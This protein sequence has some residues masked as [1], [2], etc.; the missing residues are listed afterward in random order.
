M[1]ATAHPATVAALAK[2]ASDRAKKGRADLKA[3]AYSFSED[4]TLHVEGTVLV[5]EDETYVPTTSV[6]TKATLALFMRYAGVT[7]PAALEALKRAMTE[8]I[9]LDSKAAGALAEMADIEATEA[10]VVAG[11]EALPKKTRKGKV[12]V[13]AT[14]NVVGEV[15]E[16]F[17]ET[18]KVA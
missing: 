5:S 17:E 2:L 1:T 18:T 9:E 4:I 12:N 16:T 15:V 10:A 3:G 14:M 7:G 8:A 13:K 11:M 6:P